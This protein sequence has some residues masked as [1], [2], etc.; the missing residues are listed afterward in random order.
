[1]PEWPPGSLLA[2]LPDAA[3]ERLL[4]RGVLVR[5]PG[6]GRILIREHDETRFVIVL[7]SGVVKV[8]GNAMDGRDVLL[9][10][11]MGGD[12]VGEFA[13][14]DQ[15]P[16]SATV[17]TCGIVVARVIK[18]EDFI[19]CMRRDPDISHAIS[20]AIVAKTR[21]ANQYRID[22]ASTDVRGRVARV[23]LYL[24]SSYG[25]LPSAGQHGKAVIDA[26]LTQ[27]ELGSLAA[28]SPPAVQRVLRRLRECGLIETGYRSIAVLDIERLRD[29][30]YGEP[31]RSG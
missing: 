1:M 7:L 27:A 28:A 21:V 9:A 17:V 14:V 29:V 31:S 19:D 6:P 30:A 22:F 23:L 11:R 16:R 10:V 25:R 15:L 24:V 20:K 18:A 13:A 26:P 4:S 3:R 2:M 12:V 5:H 8:T